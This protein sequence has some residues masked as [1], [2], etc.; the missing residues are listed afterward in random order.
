ME[1]CQVCHKTFPNILSI[2]RHITQRHK[3]KTGSYYAKY[4]APPY[5]CE[6]CGKPCNFLSL[7]EG[8]SKTCGKRCG[9]IK[10][11]ER[12][13]DSLPK[14][15]R[16]LDIIT[17]KAVALWE[18]RYNTNNV[19]NFFN[20]TLS[21]DDTRFVPFGIIDDGISSEDSSLISF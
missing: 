9:G 18:H 16:Y 6:N 2:T 13:K 8:Y 21:E 10:R 17:A 12:L 7:S 20:H 4:I 11:R 14:L 3:M 1:E 19:P 15:N 5:P